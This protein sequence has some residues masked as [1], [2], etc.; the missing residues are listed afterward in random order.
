VRA[1]LAAGR[2]QP[3]QRSEPSPP[4]PS[5][6]TSSPYSPTLRK[7]MATPSGS[8]WPSTHSMLSVRSS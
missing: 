3:L 8:V 1:D 6:I 5:S 2:V 7:A 4:G